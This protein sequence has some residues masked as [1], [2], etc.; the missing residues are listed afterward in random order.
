[1]LKCLS[2]RILSLPEEV[3]PFGHFTYELLKLNVIRDMTKVLRNVDSKVKSTE[4]LHSS[5]STGP[6][7]HLA[8]QNW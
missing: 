2:A 1:M 8:F 6:H 3:T 4:N 7:R 5:G